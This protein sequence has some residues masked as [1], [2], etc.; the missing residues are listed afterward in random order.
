MRDCAHFLNKRTRT[1][2]LEA[3]IAEGGAYVIS[4]IV[5][6]C[7]CISISISISISRGGKEE[8]PLDRS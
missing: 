2:H 3:A 5:S 7:V 8:L 4:M 1:T 6:L